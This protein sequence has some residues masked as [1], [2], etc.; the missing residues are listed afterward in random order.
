MLRDLTNHFIALIVTKSVVDVFEVVQVDE[1]NCK[2]RPVTFL[3]DV[4]QKRPVVW[5]ARELIFVE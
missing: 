3:L 4:L 5:Q 2:F 1:Q